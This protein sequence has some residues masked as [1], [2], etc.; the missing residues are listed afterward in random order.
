MRIRLAERR[1][2]PRLRELLRDSAMPGWVRVAYARE[3]D[4]FASLAVDGRFSQVVAGEKDGRIRG[5]G[6]RSLKPVYIN[7]R[8]G[9]IGY[10]GNLRLE[11]AYRS[12]LGLYRGYRFFADLHRD[13]RTPAYLTT[14]VEANR[15]ARTLLTSGRAGL[16]RYLDMGRYITHA[17]PPGRAPK[18]GT[19]EGLSVAR[20]G[21][22][23][24][25][26]IPAHLHREGPKRQFFPLF[27]LDD[28][29]TPH[30]R[31]L[32]ERDFYV[33]RKGGRI[34]GVAARWDQRAFKQHRVTGYARPLSR[35][36][37]LVNPLLSLAGYP[38][39]PPP[40]GALKTGYVAFPCI[41]N[42]APGV[43][44]ALLRR[45]AADAGRAG[46]D[47][48]IVG[49]HESDPLRRGLVPF[50]GFRYISRVYLVAYDDGSP[51]YETLD[52]SRIPHLEV[53][54]L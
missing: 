2:D 30:L 45:M 32:S 47:L 20:G 33:A 39:L 8:P 16:P 50:S 5:M 15:A 48:L 13:G 9:T 36:R 46:D 1:D 14:I 49:L 53:G 54:T 44:T 37:P 4:F 38:R 28:L 6:T 21:P 3:P 17:L 22:D 7:G 27:S 31:G 11:P 43:F 18:T 35:L 52:R 29:G 24:M 40:G 12:G 23:V 51:F 42:D 26:D 25:A 34:V 41:R 10:L 19:D